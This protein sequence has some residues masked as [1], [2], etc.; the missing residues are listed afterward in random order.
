[1]ACV[2]PWNSGGPHCDA[3][4]K[5]CGCHDM[6]LLGVGRAGKTMAVFQMECRYCF[7]HH[8]V[9]EPI[10]ESGLSPLQGAIPLAP[11]R[12]LP[13]RAEAERFL[14]KAALEELDSYS[15][16]LVRDRLGWS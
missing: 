3:K 2:V 14:S 8:A 13:T 15:R 9:R 6:R 5:R 4:C 1:M 11:G 10:P 7:T 16:N 12:S